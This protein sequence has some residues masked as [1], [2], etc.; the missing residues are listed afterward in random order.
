MKK[1]LFQTCLVF[2]FVS[3]SHLAQATEYQATVIHIADGDTLTVLNEFKEEVKIRLNGIDCPETGQP[4]GN[5]AKQYT[6]IMAHGETVTLHTYGQDKYGRT[7][8][9]VILKDGRN[10][11]KELVSAGY[12][13]WFFKYS[14]GGHLAI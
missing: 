9:D 10:L 6:K 1:I 7:I 11:S 5:K 14:D 3:L 8:A 4:F 13:W 12:A 2:L